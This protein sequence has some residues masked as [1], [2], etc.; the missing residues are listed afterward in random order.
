MI[1][2]CIHANFI[3]RLGLN[4]NG[5]PRLKKYLKQKINKYVAK[6]SLTFNADKIQ[7]VLLALHDKKDDPYATIYGVS[8][9][10]LTLVCKG[11]KR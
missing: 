4:L 8:I 11:V 5:L 3:D 6:K 7:E 10:I 9:E 2:S 1:Y